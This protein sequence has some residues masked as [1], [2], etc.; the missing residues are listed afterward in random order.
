MTHAEVQ[1]GFLDRAIVHEGVRYPYQ[2][3]V[4]ANYDAARMW[5]VVLFLHG[6]GERGTDGLLQTTVGIANAIRRNP[7]RYPA[8]VV[9][10]Q[11]PR[12]SFWV[13][14]PGEAALL[15]LDRIQAEFSV[16]DARI[17]LT[18]LS[19]GGHGS[20]MLGYH[21]A[22]RFAAML[23]ICGFVGDRPNRPSVVPSG[24]GTPYERV[25]A[26]LREMPIWIVH[27][28]AD[29]AVSV[30]ESR[31]MNDALRA[32]GAAVQYTELPGTDHDAW[33]PAYDSEAIISWLFAQRRTRS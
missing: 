31:R 32:V 5:P 10:P 22:A 27:G 17:Y 8:I 14:P 11:A 9:M 26:R 2:V 33:T 12:D 20:W 25:A 1:T 15:A 3:Y 23:V 16:D 24:E 28:E 30:V 6:A 19:M 7:Q 29:Q 18:G 4:P 21:H 13:G